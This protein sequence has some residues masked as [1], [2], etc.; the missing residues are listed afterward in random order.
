MLG[1][2]V[3]LQEGV[4]DV[5]RVRDIDGEGDRPPALPVLQPIGNH[6]SDELV[7]IHPRRQGR[8]DIV[9]GLRSHALGDVVIDRRVD[10]RRDQ[11]PELYQLR[12]LRRLDHRLEDIAEPAAVTTARR[13]G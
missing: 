1:S 11:M 13:C 2:N 5:D 6:I 12:D 9:A 4:P 7:G 8:H 10:L 3:E